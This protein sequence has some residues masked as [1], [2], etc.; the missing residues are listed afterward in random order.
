[1]VPHVQDANEARAVGETC[2]YVPLG[3]RSAAG[4]LPSPVMPS[5]RNRKSIAG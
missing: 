3:H 5:C 4:S 1:M 2:R